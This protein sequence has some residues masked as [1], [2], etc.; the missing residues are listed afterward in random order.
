MMRRTALPW[1]LFIALL[2]ATQQVEPRTHTI[3]MR[4]NSFAPRAVTVALGDT[5]SWLNTDIVRHNAVRS[6]LF[7]SGDIRPGERFTW[8]PADTGTV[9]YECTIHT[10]MR[11]TIRVQLPR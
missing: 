3:R 8:V 6:Q 2:G 10:R 5:V 11:G 4:G 7:D 1:L 9:R